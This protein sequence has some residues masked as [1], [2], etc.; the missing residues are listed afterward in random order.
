MVNKITKNLIILGA[1]IF[2]FALANGASAYYNA[3]DSASW[4]NSNTISTMQ[5]SQYDPSAFASQYYGYYP[6]QNANPYNSTTGYN[7]YNYYQQAIPTTPIVVPK[8]NIVNNYY[9]TVPVTPR[10]NTVT[11]TTNTTNTT[12]PYTNRIPA[13]TNVSNANTPGYNNSALGAS[14]YNSYGQAGG[15]IT[16]LSLKGSGSF[17]PSSIWQWIFVIILILVIIIIARMLTNKTV[18]LQDSHIAHAH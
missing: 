6:Q 2:T 7:Q 13:N 14:A 4:L 18:V 10:T 16:A 1:I 5:T 12:D 11:Y 3:Y 8:T 17:M 9:Q 15:G